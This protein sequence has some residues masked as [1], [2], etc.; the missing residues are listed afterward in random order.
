MKQ[1][2]ARKDGERVQTLREHCEN[3]AALASADCAPLRSLLRLCGLLH[4]LGKATE[5]FQRYLVEGV[6][7]RGSVEHAIHG[8]AYA[9]A[10]W[11]NGDSFRLLTAE[12]IA[13]AVA[14]H[15]G[16]LPDVLNADGEPYTRPEA[17]PDDLPE[18]LGGFFVQVAPESELDAL[19]AA[20]VDVD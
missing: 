5:A 18:A 16:R 12:L 6:G 9:W 14:S 13:N 3:V 17:T 11:H 10:R 8:A 1:L 19:F 4:D 15:H 7:E 20:A 2:Y